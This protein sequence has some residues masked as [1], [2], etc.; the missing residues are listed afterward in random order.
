MTE[1]KEMW[2]V[3]DLVSMVNEVQTAEIEW[4]GKTLK[5]QWCELVEAE[6]PKMV[7]PDDNAPSEEQTEYYKQL[8]GARVLKMLEKANEKSPETKTLG[9]ENWDN[10]PTTLRW[11]ISSKVLGQSSENFTTG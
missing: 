11:Q 8:A 2:T 7:M 6:E 4:S 10:L 1:E 3:D 5:I 9:E